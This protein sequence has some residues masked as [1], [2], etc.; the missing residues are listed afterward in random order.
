MT[1]DVRDFEL[2]ALGRAQ[3]QSASAA[4]RGSHAGGL[5]LRNKAGRQ[6]DVKLRLR[7]YYYVDGSLSMRLV[8]DW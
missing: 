1:R 4:T 6:Q 5:G 3:L 2:S 8:R 7:G